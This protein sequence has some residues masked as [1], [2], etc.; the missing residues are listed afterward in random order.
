MRA[1]SWNRKFAWRICVEVPRPLFTRQALLLNLLL[2]RH[3]GMKQCL[4]TRWTTWNVHIDWNIAVNPFEHIVS[5]LEWAARNRAGAHGND[6]FGL[7]HL[8]VKPDDLRSHFLGYGA[9]D[10]HEISLPGRRTEHFSAKPCQIISGHA[11]GNHFDSAT[12]EAK[13]QWPNGVFA[14]PIVEFF[15]F[16]GED[17]LLAQFIL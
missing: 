12:G 2:Q 9:G 10:D 3:E 8:I 5:L 4:G 15:Q 17:A 1:V 6:V 16:Q 11:G 7:G 13:L 14:T